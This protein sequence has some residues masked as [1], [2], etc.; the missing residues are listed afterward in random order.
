MT[1][2]ERKTVNG[3]HVDAP[4]NASLSLKGDLT[5]AVTLAPDVAWRQLHHLESLATRGRGTDNRRSE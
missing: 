4:N 5:K 3:S 1:T 2:E